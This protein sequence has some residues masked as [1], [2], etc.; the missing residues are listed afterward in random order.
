MLVPGWTQYSPGWS[1]VVGHPRLVPACTQYSPG[2]SKLVHNAPYS[3]QA[4]IQL[5]P[6]WYVYVQAYI[7]NSQG[8]FQ[9]VDNTPQ[10]GPRLYTRHPML[11]PTKS[12]KNF[13]GS[14]V[15]SWLFRV[16][17]SMSVSAA[18]V[19]PDPYRNCLTLW[20]YFLQGKSADSK[21]T[22]NITQHA[23]S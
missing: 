16:D 10:A 15:R 8:W 22:W 18:S 4:C 14:K 3:G 11:V 5:S 13:P 21:N 23:K 2:W 20:W 1:Q 7:Q 19:G 6:G 17:L 12:M 9:L